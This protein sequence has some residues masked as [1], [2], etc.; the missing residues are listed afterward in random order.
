MLSVQYVVLLLLG[1]MFCIYLWF[2]WPK[3]LLN[4]NISLLILC[5]DDIYVVERVIDVSC[6]YCM[7]VYFFLQIC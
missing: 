2:I 7:V 4:A 6:N 1:G 5:L 3:V